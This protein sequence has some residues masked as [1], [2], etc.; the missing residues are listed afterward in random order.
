MGPEG[1][2]EA[3]R[4]S[5][6]KAHYLAKTLSAVPGFGLKCRGEF[7]HEFVTECPIG[8]EALLSALEKKD[9]LGGLPLP[10]G[11]ILWCA[12]ELNTKAEMDLVAET[13]REVCCK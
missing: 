5:A 11:G 4:Q 3:A 2:K 6:S 1:L 7:F 10:D 9:V 12:T 8:P 13:A